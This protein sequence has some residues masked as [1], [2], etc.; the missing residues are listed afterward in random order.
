MGKRFAACQRL[1]GGTTAVEHC[2]GE[3]G[4]GVVGDT[5]QHYFGG[6]NVVTV[7]GPATALLCSKRCEILSKVEISM[8][9]GMHGAKTL[10]VR[11]DDINM[12]SICW[13]Q[14]PLW[15]EVFELAICARVEAIGPQELRSSG[16]EPCDAIQWHTN[17]L[18]GLA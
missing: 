13:I 18:Q 14:P 1:S 10:S 15:V 2:R 9:K 8:T 6:C 16:V 11:V 7:G 12:L 17:F 5:L 3:V 4:E